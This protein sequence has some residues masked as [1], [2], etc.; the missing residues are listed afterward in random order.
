M[1]SRLLYTACLLALALALGAGCG[2]DGKTAPGEGAPPSGPVA[3]VAGIVPLAGIVERVGGTDVSVQ[4][5][6]QPGQS[7]HAFE[8]TPRQM[9]GLAKAE[10][11]FRI[12][13][14]F[15]TELLAKIKG[16]HADLRVA[17]AREGM[18]M[19]PMEAGHDDHAD[20]DGHGHHH[21]HGED[22]PH[23]W[24]DPLRV[25]QIA[26]MVCGALCELRPERKASFE[27]NCA[28]FENE[29]DE[30]HA[31]I[32]E[33]LKPFAGRSFFVYHP[34]FGYFADRYGLR[35]VAIE[36]EGKQPS[37]K[38]LEACQD[39]ARRA[40]VKAI[41]VQPEFSEHTA[42]AIAERLGLDVVRLDPLRKDLA[43]SLE[44]IAEA[45]AAGFRPLEKEAP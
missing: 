22:D 23:I 25:K 12:G 19:L 30:V 11:Y 35:Q 13:E 41:F 1:Q 7:P 28:S 26:R 27:T 32:A 17:D 16:I 38:W 34:A 4:P 33:K 2:P 24:L 10:V 37:M 21:G 31:R 44:A 5:L 29:L 36:Q 40:G 45:V 42:R 9:D 8:P 18:T 15:E 14:A 6:V 20:H 39:K 43:A 3:A